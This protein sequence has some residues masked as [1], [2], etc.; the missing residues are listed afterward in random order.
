MQNFIFSRS[1]STN[2]VKNQDRIDQGVGSG[3]LSCLFE[4]F[5]A[6]IPVRHLHG[7]THMHLH[8]YQ[9]GKAAVKGIIVGHIAHQDIVDIV[10]HPVTPYNNVTFIPVVTPDMCS[11]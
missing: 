5:D 11:E 1:A 8:T 7:R 10:L 2:Q 6:Y 4:F 9:T 3:V